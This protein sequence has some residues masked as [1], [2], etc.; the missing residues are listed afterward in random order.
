MSTVDSVC[1]QCLINSKCLKK[2]SA[3]ESARMDTNII[4]AYH[5]NNSFIASGESV[6]YAAISGIEIT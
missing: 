5:W 2:N 3:N 1:I 6:L 4:P